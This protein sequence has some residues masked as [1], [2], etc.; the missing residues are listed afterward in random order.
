MLIAHLTSRR[1]PGGTATAGNPLVWISPEG[2]R[3]EYEL[4]KPRRPDEKQRERH[5]AGGPRRTARRENDRDRDRYRPRRGLQYRAGRQAGRCRAA[6]RGESGPARDRRTR[7][8]RARPRSR[9]GS[10]TARRSSQAG[11]GTESAV[12]QLRTRSEWTEWVLLFLLV[13]L[14]GEALWAW[15]VRPGVVMI[16]Y[17]ADRHDASRSEASYPPRPRL[18]GGEGWGEGVGL[19]APGCLTP[20]RR[21]SAVDLSPA[22]PGAR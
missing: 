1:V 8:S 12:N 18:C 3:V 19:P 2:N 20:H 15:T 14:V 22:K 5:Q 17:A 21:R 4:V 9:T 13:L 16:G 6:L 11:A 10:G 7:R